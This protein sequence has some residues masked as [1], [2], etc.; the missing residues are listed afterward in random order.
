M[1][2]LV[3]QRFHEMRTSVLHG[4]LRACDAFNFLDKLER[5]PHPTLVACGTADKMTPLRYSQYL[6]NK[7]PRGQLVIV[8]NAG[9]MLMLEKPRETADILQDFIAQI[10]FNGP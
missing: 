2:A 9:H 4:D 3:R 6:A 1:V 10:Q 7:I 5:I 8:Q